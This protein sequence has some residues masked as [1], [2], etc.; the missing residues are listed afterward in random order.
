MKKLA[1]LIIFFPSILF[2]EG[3]M[4]KIS[5][6]GNLNNIPLKITNID[7]YTKKAIGFKMNN[8]ILS[9]GSSFLLG[10]KSSSNFSRN[11]I[12]KNNIY[13]KFKFKF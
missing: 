3:K 13:V 6:E 12:S 10:S 5:L 11:K 1:F 9:P 7:K 4:F 8:W 2:A